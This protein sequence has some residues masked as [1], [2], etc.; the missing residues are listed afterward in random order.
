M[1]SKKE[2]NVRHAASLITSYLASWWF[3]GAAPPVRS[4]SEIPMKS[5][6]KSVE[7]SQLEVGSAFCQVKLCAVML[8]AK[9]GTTL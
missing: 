5:I 7:P 9:W 3:F 8:A 1:T 2:Y 6:V 4:W